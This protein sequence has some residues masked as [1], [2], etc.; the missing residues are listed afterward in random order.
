MSRKFTIVAALV[1]VAATVA[2]GVR[3]RASRR[4]AATVNT[5]ANRSDKYE[6][7]KI[8]ADYGEAIATVE[9]KYA[10]EIETLGPWC[11]HAEICQ[12]SVLTR[13]TSPGVAGSVNVMTA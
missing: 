7:D 6:A 12:S 4:H 11:G 5:N 9:E 1:I 13:R 2:G 3:S 10:G 8:E